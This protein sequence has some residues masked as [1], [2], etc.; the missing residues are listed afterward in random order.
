VPRVA[1][2]RAAAAIAL[3]V[4]TGCSGSESV[5]GPDAAA[6]EDASKSATD[7]TVGSGSMDATMDGSSTDGSP[8]VS[9]TDDEAGIPGVDAE[10]G[11]DATVG[12]SDADAGDAQSGVLLH[13]CPGPLSTATASTL[14]DG[15]TVDPAMSWLY[16][17]SGTVF[18]PGIPAPIL[19][20]TPQQGGT[21]AALLHLH[22]RLFDYQG[23]FAPTNPGQLA[24]PTTAWATAAAQS[25]GA[26]D[27]LTVEL[28]TSVGSVVSG[29]IAET[30]ILASGPL[31]GVLYYDTYGSHLVPGQAATGNGAVM[32]LVPGAA[33]PTAFLYM[34]AGASPFGPCVTCH[35]VAANGSLFAAES[36]FFPN[37]DPLYGKG[38][39]SFVLSSA[40]QP[41]PWAPTAST[42]NDSWGFA[43]VYP[44]GT[45]LLT[46]G[47]PADS[48]A[49]TLFPG[50]AGNN[51]GMIGPK[52]T[53]MYA[54]STAHPIAFTGLSA[55]YAMMPMFSPD[56]THVVYN[57]YDAG[58]G[59]TLTV[60][61]FDVSSKTFS[62]ATTVFHDAT[63]YPGWPAFTA[64]GQWVVFAL[65]NTNN[66]AT[67]EPPLPAPPFS[68]QLYIVS[69]AGGT[70]QRLDALSGYRG[71]Q[72]YLP[73]GGG[74]EGLDF[75]PSV[76]P[77]ASGGYF[78]V[79]FTSRRSYGN[80][81]NKGSGD[82]GSKAIWAA[83]LDIA[84]DAGQDPSHP[85]FYMPGQELGSGNFR[86]T[87]ALARCKADGSSCASGFDCCGGACTGGK[88]ALPSGCSSE[89]ARCTNGADCCNAAARCIG[90]YCASIAR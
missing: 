69:A 66:Y 74:N 45:L 38:S 24:V 41:D 84:G 88:C 32:E 42:L 10:A 35:A 46:S 51:P 21:S 36:E 14:L 28:T 3:L 89:N 15:G 55:Q 26:S 33:Q 16:P 17:Y 19:Q 12:A 67:E 79:Y 72:T 85:A 56:G 71:G 39:E 11:I 77:V 18:P 20:W 80:L 86:V 90:G 13:A 75:Y 54:A 43:A 23:C 8:E 87:S 60:M 2:L 7:G 63:L 48:T 61:A 62:N 40:S 37:S 82:V 5:G 58:S 81:Y 53:A 27:P 50:V 9:R 22:S 49:T 29:P 68:S 47:E 83:A 6:V 70:A 52:K 65:G 59:H 1:R 64:D 30:W 76:S 34:D 78:W 73:D 44:D 4:A 25:L 57:D 31:A